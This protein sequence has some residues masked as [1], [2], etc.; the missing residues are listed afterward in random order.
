MI[1]KYVLAKPVTTKID[2]KFQYSLEVHS[3]NFCMPMDKDAFDDM[4]V[5]L[6]ER[7]QQIRELAETFRGNIY[8][9]DNQLDKY[10]ARKRE[11]VAYTDFIDALVSLVYGEGE[12]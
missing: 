8:D 11:E 6:E 7:K 2:P 9:A 1:E 5:P 12:Q 3:E 10:E 4:F